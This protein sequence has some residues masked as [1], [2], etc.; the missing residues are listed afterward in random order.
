[1]TEKRSTYK[2]GQWAS[3]LDDIE[4]PATTAEL[5]ADWRVQCMPKGCAAG[6]EFN[7]PPE[8]MVGMG[9][10]CW[11]RGMQCRDVRYFDACSQRYIQFF[12]LK[13][14]VVLS[15]KL[16]N[17]VNA[18]ERYR[19]RQLRIQ[20][21]GDAGFSYDE[22]VAISM[23]AACQHSECPALKAC[24]YAMTAAS[25]LDLPTRAAEDFANGL[26]DAGQ[27]LKPYSIAEPLQH[28]STHSQ[29]LPN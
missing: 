20:K 2:A 9:F 29:I 19:Q 11:M 14:G 1:M 15:T 22:V 17:W 3:N 5:S 24:I 16:G 7:T 25:E 23:I 12:G 26:I 28:L 4:E 6:F 18:L 21:M 8:R 27:I 13:D 10:R